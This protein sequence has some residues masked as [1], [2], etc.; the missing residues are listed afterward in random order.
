MF[1]FDIISLTSCLIVEGKVVEKSISVHRNFRTALNTFGS[2]V[3]YQDE[4]LDFQKELTDN[5]NDKL[6]NY[7]PLRTFNRR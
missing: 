5:A 3:R 1:P 7:K 4:F 6:E 2:D